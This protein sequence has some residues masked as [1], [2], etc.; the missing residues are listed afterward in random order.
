[1]FVKIPIPCRAHLEQ[2]VTH[3]LCARSCTWHC[4]VTHGTGHCMGFALLSSPVLPKTGGGEKEMKKK[5][6]PCLPLL[7][8]FAT[9]AL[10]VSCLCLCHFTLCSLSMSEVCRNK[11]LGDCSYSSWEDVQKTEFGWKSCSR[12]LWNIGLQCFRGKSSIHTSLLPE[13]F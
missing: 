5:N 12:H 6:T 10:A 9:C 3:Q 13:K 8:P 11:G 4:S 2:F 7:F 1:M